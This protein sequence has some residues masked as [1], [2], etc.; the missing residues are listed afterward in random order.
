MNITSHEIPHHASYRS[1]HSEIEFNL[2]YA[3]PIVLD[4]SEEKGTEIYAGIIPKIMTFPN[5]S[6][7]VFTN[8][9]KILRNIM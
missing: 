7:C 6:N 3:A 2:H 4:Q 5:F 8:N 9:P 1:Q